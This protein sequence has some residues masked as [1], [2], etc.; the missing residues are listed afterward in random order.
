MVLSFIEEPILANKGVEL[1][2]NH[3]PDMIPL[4]PP[5]IPQK[6]YRQICDEI[7]STV[8]NPPNSPA[9]ECE[10][11]SDD[12]KTGDFSDCDPEEPQYYKETE[13]IHTTTT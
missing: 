6:D 3:I 9:P 7:Y 11:L 12:N 1:F 10:S 8:V 5:L 13:H 4:S 2:L